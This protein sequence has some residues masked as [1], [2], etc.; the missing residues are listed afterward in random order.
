MRPVLPRCLLRHTFLLE[1]REN[2]GIEQFIWFEDLEGRDWG[3]GLGT[4]LEVGG[5]EELV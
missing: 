5:G 2:L 4:G 1:K 3:S